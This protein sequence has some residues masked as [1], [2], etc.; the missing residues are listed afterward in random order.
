MHYA[1]YISLLTLLFIEAYNVKRRITAFTLNMAVFIVQTK[2]LFEPINH[3]L[4]HLH[5]ITYIIV[6]AVIVSFATIIFKLFISFDT[7][8]GVKWN[9]SVMTFEDNSNLADFTR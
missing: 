3:S 5:N 1:V 6:L 7:T 9:T 8:T 4:C 2:K